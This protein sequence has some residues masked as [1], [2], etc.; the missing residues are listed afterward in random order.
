M[1]NAVI[2]FAVVVVV[3]ADGLVGHQSNAVPLPRN[4]SSYA[5]GTYN[6][7]IVTP[8]ANGGTRTYVLHIPK[9]YDP[10][11]TYPLVLL[12]HG[13]HATGAQQL[14]VTKF[15]P[16]ADHEGFIIVAPDGI[17]K[18][19]NDG[20]LPTNTNINTSVNTRI[21][22]VGF[23]R[24]LVPHLESEL[25]ID[26]NRIYATGISNGGHFSQWLGCHMADVFAAIGADA[27]EIPTDDVPLCKPA[28]PISVIGIHGTAD[29]LEPIGGGK[30]GGG[31]S[32]SY[33][34]FVASAAQTMQMWATFNGCSATPTV[35]H[36]A[37]A[38]QDRTSVDEYSYSGCKAGTSVVYYMVKGMGHVWPPVQGVGLGSLFTDI[39]GPTSQNINATDIFWAFF[40]AHRR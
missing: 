38:V 24:L 2:G 27:G 1:R 3:V 7:S 12:F 4:A 17:N 8:P 34:G 26:R 40:N 21:N 39:T 37:A 23:V 13:S 29:P 18:H 30:S 25:P 36:I 31:Y 10:T 32:T 20:K 14:R 5:P 11:K 35:T 6:E 9:G 19:W 22:D 16:K 15:A 28:A 33:G